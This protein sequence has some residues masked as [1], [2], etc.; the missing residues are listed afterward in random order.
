M[1]QPDNRGPEKGEGLSENQLEV[2]Q[3]LESAGEHDVG[4]LNIAVHGI[5][6]EG[7]QAGLRGC[8][9]FHQA[10]PIWRLCFAENGGHST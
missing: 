8:R 1:S 10:T 2:T 5:S 4:G 7:K 6:R 9:Y 3:F